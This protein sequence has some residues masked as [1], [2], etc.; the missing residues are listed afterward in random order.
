VIGGDLGSEGGELEKTQARSE[1]LEEN[2]KAGFTWDS[3]KVMQEVLRK[4]MERE[5]RFRVMR[6]PGQ[7][8]PG[9]SEGNSEIRDFAS[10]S[11]FYPPG[12]TPR[13]K[14]RRIRRSDIQ[15]HRTSIRCY[16]FN[17]KLP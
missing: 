14:E 11:S 6:N 1:E 17:P 2:A 8:L 7:G 3:E 15:L 4:K 12:D 9:E 13:L 5:E 10:E 16:P